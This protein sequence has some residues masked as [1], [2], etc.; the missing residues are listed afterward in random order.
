MP[1]STSLTTQTKQELGQAKARLQR[2]ILKR[3]PQS[4]SAEEWDSHFH[5]MPIHYWQNLSHRTLSS[6]LE[7]VHAFFEG[8]M[9]P[10]K[11]GFEPILHWEAAKNQKSAT[12]TVCTWDRTALF[13]KIA[14]ALSLAGIQ[15]VEAE[16]YTR[17]DHVV[18]DIFRVCD[19]TGRKMPNLKQQLSTKK[20]LTQ[21]LKSNDL[22]A[23]HNAFQKLRS[24]RSRQESTIVHPRIFF[25]NHASASHTLLEIQASDRLGLL[26]HILDVLSHNHVNISQAKI[27]TIRS[28]T[29][30]SFLITTWKSQK[31]TDPLLLHSIQD[32]LIETLKHLSGLK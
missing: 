23:L 14:G 27:R 10:K 16:I 6:H 2:A 5:C 32:Q 19:S 11:K 4:G 9:Q 25:D 29:K 8:L 30:D 1:N 17:S 31:A 18:L 21:S 26:F 13:A 28:K 15:I 24:R 22:S 12:L 20:T 7:I 3:P